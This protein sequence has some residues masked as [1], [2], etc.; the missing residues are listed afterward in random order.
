MTAIQQE[1]AQ[2]QI[3]FEGLV[4]SW[5]ALNRSERKREWSSYLDLTDEG[6]AGWHRFARLLINSWRRC[7]RRGFGP[8]FCAPGHV[9]STRFV[10]TNG[11]APFRIS[12]W[13]RV[14]RPLEVLEESRA[15]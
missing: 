11:R 12:Q 2:L 7:R 5:N 10:Q 4:A 6:G 13:V 15:G 8:F 14:R 1:I 3:E 9:P